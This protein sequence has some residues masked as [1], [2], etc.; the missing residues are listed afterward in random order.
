[1]IKKIYVIDKIHVKIGMLSRV[2]LQPLRLAKNVSLSVYTKGYTSS[3]GP[4]HLFV[5][6][7]L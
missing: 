4:P 2:I 3:S 5:I 1:M 6:M 7:V